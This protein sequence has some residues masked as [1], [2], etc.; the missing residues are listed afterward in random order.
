MNRGQKAI[1]AIAIFL[2]AILLITVVCY[3][4]RRI[5]PTKPDGW[6]EFGAIVAIGA[7]GVSSVF[8]ALLSALSLH[9]QTTAARDIIGR[10]G[11]IAKTLETF[12]NGLAKDLEEFKRDL[13]TDLEATKRKLDARQAAYETIFVAASN[14]F[15]QLQLL[16]KGEFNPEDIK[17]AED[18]MATA[19]GHASNVDA[20]LQNLFLDFFQKGFYLS[21]KASKVKTQQSYKELWRDLGGELGKS[22][23]AL[24]DASPYK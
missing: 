11:D 7:T 13:S 10:Q 18:Q 12:K 15:H 5:K 1:F 24:S 3:A 4:Y 23:A 2:Y 14:Y 22:L 17:E 19:R 20:N 6:K 16:S 21:D 9:V 8:A